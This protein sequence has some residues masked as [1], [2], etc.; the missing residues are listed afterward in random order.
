[1]EYAAPHNP[2]HD[3]ATD[4]YKPRTFVDNPRQPKSDLQTA[5]SMDLNRALGE[6]VEVTTMPDPVEDREAAPGVEAPK[7]KKESKPVLDAQQTDILVTV[8]VS[9]AEA[10]VLALVLYL[11][12][13]R[14]V[15]IKKLAATTAI[16]WVILVSVSMFPFMSVGF[17]VALGASVA[18][19]LVKYI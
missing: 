14:R 13:N 11:A 3:M 5:R 10:L 8:A 1:M 2:V 19:A 17:R 6:S 7:K 16:V 4:Y 15:G 12:S 18:V 9:L